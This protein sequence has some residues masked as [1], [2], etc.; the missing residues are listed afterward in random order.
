[1]SREEDVSSQTTISESTDATRKSRNESNGSMDKPPG[2]Q[3]VKANP[4]KRTVTDYK[5][6]SREI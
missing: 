1:M 4:K 2:A 3:K 6:E 5:G